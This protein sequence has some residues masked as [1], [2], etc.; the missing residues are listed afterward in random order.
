MQKEI[1]AYLA[2]EKSR[3]LYGVIIPK[4]SHASIIGRGGVGINDLSTKHNVRILFPN[5]KEN[6]VGAGDELVNAAEVQDAE[7][8][9]LIRIVGLESDCKAAA[10]EM[11]SKQASTP[12]RGSRSATP[13]ASV[14]RTVEVPAHLH[15][16]IA[17]GGRFFRR[18]IPSRVNVDHAGAT[19]P[20]S[21]PKPKVN[22]S[23]DG[24]G[25]RID[26][27]EEDAPTSGGSI[28]ESWDVVPLFS[29][30]PQESSTIPWVI[31]GQNEENVAKAEAAVQAAVERVKDWTHIAYAKVGRANM[32]RVIGKGGAG[33]ENL[34]AV[35]RGE[36]E[37]LGRRD[38]DTSKRS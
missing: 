34:R 22:S 24:A 36:V 33:L 3:V 11:L 37:A 14:S 20:P 19:L 31:S 28:L 7:P 23:A 35:S 2:R 29:A 25:A 8:E 21:L 12:A 10:E 15:R 16:V 1:E 27:D 38:A 6:S 32:P 17:D 13:Q 18:N 26:M 30:E 5:W 9:S 4:S